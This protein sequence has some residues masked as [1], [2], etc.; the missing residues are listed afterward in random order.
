MT[1]SD[2]LARIAGILEDAGVPYM[3]TGSLAAAFYAALRATQD[4]DV[5]LDST[6]EGVDAVVDR[7]EAAGLY[8]SREAA[9][10]AYRRRGVF[11][12]IDPDQGWKADFIFRK[13]RPFSVAEFARRRRA[14]VLGI[15]VSIASIE[16]L[17]VAKLE[18]AALGDSELQRRDVLQ[19]LEQAADSLDR[20]YVS[21][22]VE[23][24][25]IRADWDEALA[26]LHGDQKPQAH[27][28]ASSSTTP[29]AP[30]TATSPAS[31]RASSRVPSTAARPSLKARFERLASR[32][33]RQ[34]VDASTRSCATS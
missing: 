1:I 6:L 20:A 18:W 27:P 19:L 16:D 29:T 22:W 21:E 10:E 26:R 4:L 32:M 11:N 7:L 8:G 13:E 23:K 25:G 34:P 30:A 3:I 9:H 14:G 15:E 33:S 17:I 5:V 2:L 24:L 12:A 31:R 28:H